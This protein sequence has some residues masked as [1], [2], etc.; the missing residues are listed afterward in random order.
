MFSIYEIPLTSLPF[1]GFLE[2][3]VPAFSGAKVFLILIGIFTQVGQTFLTFGYKLLPASKASTM[4]YIQV[5][6]AALSGTFI[7]HE[8]ITYNFLFGSFLIFLAVIFVIKKS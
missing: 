4:S 6:L 1:L 2:I 5:P 8:N 7:F 3:K